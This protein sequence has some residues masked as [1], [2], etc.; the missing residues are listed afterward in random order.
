[1]AAKLNSSK[2]KRI[3][4]IA[5]RGCV[6]RM[7]CEH[8]FQGMVFHL[9]K[10]RAQRRPVAAISAKRTKRRGVELTAGGS[11]GSY[12]VYG[13]AFAF[14]DRH[15]EQRLPEGFSP[16]VQ[17]NV[18]PRTMWPTPNNSPH[19]LRPKVAGNHAHNGH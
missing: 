2:I 12:A 6:Q 18:T 4:D 1:M 19:R 9:A 8:T 3:V 11:G 13:V 5:V 17:N 15:A 10:K 7:I 16:V 14:L